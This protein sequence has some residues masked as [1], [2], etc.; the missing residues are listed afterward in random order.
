MLGYLHENGICVAVQYTKAIQYYERAIDLGHSFSMNNFGVMLEQGRGVTADLNRAAQ[1]YRNAITLYNTSAMINLALIHQCGKGTFPK[2]IEGAI[3]LYKTAAECG[4]KNAIAHLGLIYEMG[5]G[6]HRNLTIAVKYYRAASSSN[7]ALNNLGRLH[8]LG[9][10]VGQN[11]VLAFTLLKKAADG[12]SMIAQ[13]NVGMLFESG[14]GTP[15]NMS[16]AARYYK[17]AHAQGDKMA[18]LQF[19]KLNQRIFLRRITS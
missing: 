14:T 19:D 11:L 2:D 8:F 13:V 7:L 1:H 3:K 6:V 9:H 15:K 10:G 16:E 12:G 18:S 5:H 4:N 17:L